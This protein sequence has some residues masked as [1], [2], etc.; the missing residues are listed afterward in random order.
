MTEI[1]HGSSAAAYQRCRKRPE[2]SCE[3]CKRAATEYVRKWR[4]TQ[5]PA[6]SKERALLKRSATRRAKTR[7]AA[8]HPNDYQHLLAEELA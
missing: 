2:G 6:F 1:D 7:L 5:Q 8:M 4:A 3:A